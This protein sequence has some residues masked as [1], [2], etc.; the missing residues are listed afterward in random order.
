MKIELLLQLIKNQNFTKNTIY[1]NIDVKDFIN[2]KISDFFGNKTRNWVVE[3]EESQLVGFVKHLAFALNGYYLH[4]PTAQYQISE[5][6]SKLAKSLLAFENNDI[7]LALFSYQ[8]VLQN[9]TNLRDF[10]KILDDGKPT[11]HVEFPT[12]ELE[13]VTLWESELQFLEL[14]AQFGIAQDQYSSKVSPNNTAAL[15][16]PFNEDKNPTTLY[17]R[18]L[19][20][21]NAN[22]CKKEDLI[23]YEAW[24]GTESERVRHRLVEHNRTKGLAWLDGIEIDINFVNS[25]TIGFSSVDLF[26]K[27]FEIPLTQIGFHADQS[28]L[29][30]QHKELSEPSVIHFD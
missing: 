9:T 3:S 17:H 29:I 4:E 11:Q 5:R 7:E 28:R 27:P 18:E 8:S 1:S 24:F 14:A 12:K 30:F 25:H 10:E 23:R 13:T 16:E 21:I 15:T 20:F 22:I 2:C 26:F 6:H 19:G